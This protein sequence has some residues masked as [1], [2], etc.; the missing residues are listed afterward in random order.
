M[1]GSEIAVVQLSRQWTAMGY[2]VTVYC[3][4]AA[5]LVDH[6][7]TYTP[8]Y[9]LNASD[10][11]NILIVW[12]YPRWLDLPLHAARMYLDLHDMPREM[13][14]F[15]HLATDRLAQVH[16]VF[17]KS[18]FHRCAFP[19]VPPSKAMIVSNGIAL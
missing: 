19:E 11:F 5:E 18:D 15:D 8:Y 14:P 16:K 7:V 10:L 17:F 3:D 4:C 13:D 9:T 1:G 12:R 2:R 6:G